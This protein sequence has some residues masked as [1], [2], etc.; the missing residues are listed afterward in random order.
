M[1]LRPI[2]EENSLTI[3]YH[4]ICVSTHITVVLHSSS[5]FIVRTTKTLNDDVT[6]INIYLYM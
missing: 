6:Q 2:S 3:S 5:L 4:A 1:R